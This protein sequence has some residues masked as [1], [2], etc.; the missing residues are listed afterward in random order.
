MVQP[1]KI[2]FCLSFLLLVGCK[3]KPIVKDAFHITL[4]KYVKEAGY[5]RGEIHIHIDYPMRRFAASGMT[6]EKADKKIYIQ[7]FVQNAAE[8][9]VEASK[10][11][12]FVP[13]GFKYGGKKEDKALLDR[14]FKDILET[15]QS[16]PEKYVFMPISDVDTTQYLASRMILLD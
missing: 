8:Y 1:L 12:P 10:G 11:Q 16:N 3:D 6:I 14:V 4:P 9:L 5:V 2:L 15:L 7:T 13:K